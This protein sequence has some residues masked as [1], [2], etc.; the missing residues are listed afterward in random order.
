[1]RSTWRAL[2]VTA[3]AIAALTAATPSYADDGGIVV[4][5]DSSGG[6]GWFVVMMV[7]AAII[8]I[9]TTVWRV[10]MAQKLARGAGMDPSLA[11]KMTLM[12]KDGLDDTYLAASL[13]GQMSPTA[14]GTES[15]G[16]GSGPWE[17][18]MAR[19]TELK[20]LLDSGA[21]TQQEYDDRRKAIIDSV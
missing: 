6:S 5:S 4:S 8:G 20:S 17:Q 11:T 3:M 14:P 21:I 15:S 1:M 10:T 19:L 12:T 16:Q 13:R 7:L 2:A 18:T 9:G